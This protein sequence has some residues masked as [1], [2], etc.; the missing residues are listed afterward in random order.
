[1]DVKEKIHRF[2]ISELKGTEIVGITLEV[3]KAVEQAGIRVES[4]GDLR[5][6][7]DGG[8]KPGAE[9]WRM[10]FF[11]TKTD[12]DELQT[13]KNAL[14]GKFD[15]PITM[16]E[17]IGIV[18]SIDADKSEFLKLIGKSAEPA[19]KNNPPERPGA[20]GQGSFFNQT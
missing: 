8:E 13:I 16:K 10:N 17:K 1:M 19:A 7:S 20:Q 4:Y 3:I 12:L 9:R 18:F 5:P 14:N 15:F 2:S 11:F 6:I